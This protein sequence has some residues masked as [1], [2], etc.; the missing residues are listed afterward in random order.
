VIEKKEI[1]M[2]QYILKNNWN[3]NCIVPYYRNLDYRII[4][5]NIN[6]PKEITDVVYKNSFFGRSLTPEEM[7]FY[8]K[9][10]FTIK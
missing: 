9:W 1:G 10:R 6:K 5:E 4:S 3:I 8:K 7:I 2:S